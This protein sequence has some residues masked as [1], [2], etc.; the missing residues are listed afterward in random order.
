MGN[1]MTLI[2][3]IIDANIRELDEDNEVDDQIKYILENG[4]ELKF[5]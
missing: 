1:L 3:K 2:T 5:F 4:C